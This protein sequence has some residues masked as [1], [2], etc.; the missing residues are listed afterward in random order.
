MLLQLLSPL[1]F[2]EVVVVIVEL[3]LLLTLRLVVVVLLLLF[4]M[5][6]LLFKIAHADLISLVSLYF[7]KC[8]TTLLQFLCTSHLIKLML[9]ICHFQMNLFTINQSVVHCSHLST[10]KPRWF[11]I[12]IHILALTFIRFFLNESPQL[13]CLILFERIEI[14]TSKPFVSHT[15]FAFQCIN[16]I[17]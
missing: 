2:V 9:T 14:R 12:L 1:L 13:F 6:L 7:E 4:M 10:L 5:L 3:L 17:L 15:V 11:L 8:I 16:L